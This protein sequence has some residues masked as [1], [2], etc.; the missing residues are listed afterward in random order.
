MHRS[1]NDAIAN[2]EPEFF[3][4][5]LDAMSEHI[6]VIDPHGAIRYVNRPWLSF[7]AANDGP[8]SIDWTS[9]NYLDVCARAEAAGDEYGRLAR[10]GIEHLA[11]GIEPEYALE[12]PCHS[13]EEQ[14][15]FMARMTRLEVAGCR[16]IVISHHDITQRKLVEERAEQLAR[17]DPLTGVAN[18]KQ[19]DEFL[20]QEWKRAMRSRK[21]LSVLLLDI[22]A[23]KLFNDH[24]GHQAGDDCL[25]RIAA[26]LRSTHRRA[27]ELVARYGGEE[28][29]VVMGDASGEHAEAGAQRTLETVRG[30]AIPHEYSDIASIVTV[31]VG[32]ATM[33]PD[34]ASAEAVIVRAADEALY[35]AK[36]D[37]GDQYRVAVDAR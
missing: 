11:H 17:T 23:F 6:A 5:I 2:T 3:R 22:D 24:Y 16:Y 25:R 35:A 37:G 13:P 4:R 36:E 14:R 15:W 21:E 1:M 33:V 10:E 18:R 27:A 7:C 8:K 9:V 32:V 26:A 12:Y 29:L 34:K 31:S 28:F 20:G 30:L 19:L